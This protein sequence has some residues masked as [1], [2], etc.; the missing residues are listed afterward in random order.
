VKLTGIEIHSKYGASDFP[1]S[2]FKQVKIG[3]NICLLFHS[4]NIGHI[5]TP[6]FFPTQSDWNEF[7]LII[8]EKFKSR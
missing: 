2:V 3:K 5:F 8:K 1:W 4:N 6:E 7:L